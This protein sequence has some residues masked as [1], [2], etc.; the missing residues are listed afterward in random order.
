MNENDI[1]HTN[2]APIAR[3]TM[4]AITEYE[5]AEAERRAAAIMQVSLELC[6]C[7]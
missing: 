2:I 1:Y 3:K 5:E 7:V 4:H 6:V